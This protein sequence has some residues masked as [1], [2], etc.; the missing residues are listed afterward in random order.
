LKLVHSIALVSILGSAAASVVCAQATP[1]AATTQPA[2][3]LS[4]GP[5]TSPAEVAAVLDALKSYNQ[6]VK[7]GDMDAVA[8]VLQ[9]NTEP[10]K[11]M[12]GIAKTLVAGGKGI[13]GAMVEK[14][15]KD[16]LAKENIAQDQFP[17]AFPELPLE[18]AKVKV[19]GA[20]AGIRF[21]ADESGPAVLT[22]AKSADG[23]WKINADGLLAGLTEQ[24]VTQQGTLI[25][26]VVEVMN[27]TAGDVKA[28][29]IDAPDEVM[30]LF[31]HR[32]EKKVREVQMKQM[33]DQL[34]P[35]MMNPPTSTGPA[36][37]ATAPTVG[38]EMP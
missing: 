34:P 35:E 12:I 4:T 13:Y 11:K 22:A 24:Q 38:P 28:G 6:A 14:F 36:G 19:E 3:A 32:V 16:A 30:A 33:Q 10:Q 18:Q 15:G 17:G 31:R 5:T 8:K 27:K 9:L 21:G 26:A 7:D 25:G 29:K 37:P 1:P 20:T 23:G 2:G